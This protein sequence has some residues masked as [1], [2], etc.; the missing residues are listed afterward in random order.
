MASPA[1]RYKSIELRGVVCG[2]AQKSTNFLH[3]DVGK[4]HPGIR[5]HLF[6]DGADCDYIPI[7]KAKANLV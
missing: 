2:N 3:C 5:D 1:G 7:A 6:A 4:C